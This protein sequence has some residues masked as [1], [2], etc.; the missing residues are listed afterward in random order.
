MHMTIYVDFLW[1]FS[2]YKPLRPILM[3]ER[4]HKRKAV[5]RVFRTIL[6]ALRILGKTETLRANKNANA[7]GGFC[8]ITS[9]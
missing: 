7:K 6:N 8:A 3:D 1:Y 5:L 9:T 4:K 2:G